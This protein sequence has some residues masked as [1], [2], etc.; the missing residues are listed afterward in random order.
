MRLPLCCRARLLFTLTPSVHPCSFTRRG[1][2]RPL[3]AFEEELAELQKLEDTPGVATLLERDAKRQERRRPG[4][5]LPSSFALLP[6]SPA[7]GCG[8]C[9][10]TPLLLTEPA[11]LCS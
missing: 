9:P 1:G 6:A 5:S 4:P 2:L 3:R 10:A 11:V 7:A 8:C